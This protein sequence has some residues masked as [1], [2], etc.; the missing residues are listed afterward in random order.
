MS[1]PSFALIALLVFTPSLQ[2]LKDHAQNF[3]LV[4]MIGLIAVIRLVA[5]I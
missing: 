2:L 1:T 3:S 4:K 5:E